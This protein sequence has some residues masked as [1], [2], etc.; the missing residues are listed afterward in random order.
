MSKWMSPYFALHLKMPESP[1]LAT[2][3]GHY[4]REPNLLSEEHQLCR[5]NSPQLLAPG[6]VTNQH[7][8]PEIEEFPG[9]QDFSEL[10]V[11]ESLVS[12]DSW[13]LPHWQT[14]WAHS[15]SASAWCH[16]PVV[17]PR[18]HFRWH[19]WVNQPA[20]KCL[21]GNS[22]NILQYLES[23]ERKHNNE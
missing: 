19:V 6:R 5:D 7:S 1:I 10:K 12:Q 15:Q 9:T 22:H 23:W 17:H 18:W 3:A 2:L 14:S 8:L 4:H 13:L 11:G 20:S 16:T 21:L